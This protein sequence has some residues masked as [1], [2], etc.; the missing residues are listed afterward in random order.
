MC[1]LPVHG[2]VFVKHQTDCSKFFICH[3]LNGFMI[4]CP[5]GTLWDE[6]LNICNHAYQVSCHKESIRNMKVR[7]PTVPTK[8]SRPAKAIDIE[9]SK[10]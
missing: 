10:N 9:S 5:A 4:E 7:K 2:T 1:T 8:P 6:N 3:G